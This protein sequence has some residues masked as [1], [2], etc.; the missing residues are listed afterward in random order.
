MQE[1]IAIRRK[2]SPIRLVK[3]KDMK[4]VKRPRLGVRAHDPQLGEYL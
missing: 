1:E 4:N 2:F 3:K